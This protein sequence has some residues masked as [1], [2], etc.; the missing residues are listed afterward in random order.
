MQGKLV[1]STVLKRLMDDN[2][3]EVLLDDIEERKLA[4]KGSGTFFANALITDFDR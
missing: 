3:E 2:R 1:K 4:S